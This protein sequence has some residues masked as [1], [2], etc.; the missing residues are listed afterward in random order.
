MSLKEWRERLRERWFLVVFGYVVLFDVV[1]FPSPEHE[2]RLL[3]A[4]PVPWVADYLWCCA[5]SG[6][7]LASR[8]PPPS[9]HEQGDAAVR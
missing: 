9:T 2:W 8:P 5:S 3:L 1:P 4:L 6:A 7:W